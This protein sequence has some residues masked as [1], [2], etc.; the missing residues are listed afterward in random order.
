M[1]V[2]SNEAILDATASCLMQGVIDWPKLLPAICA[3]GT[4]V[5]RVPIGDSGVSSSYVQP[6]Y[7]LRMAADA[8]M[9]TGSTSGTHLAK[10]LVYTLQRYD[11]AI[12]NVDIRT[13][14]AV[15]DGEAGK[16][17]AEQGSAER[18]RAS[19]SIQ[20]FCLLL[21]HYFHAN[22]AG[23]CAYA[24]SLTIM[25]TLRPKNQTCELTHPPVCRAL[26]TY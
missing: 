18:Q 4:W 14:P 25:S 13:S 6:H 23:R 24:C 15:G 5:F 16:V 12:D 19:E 8:C 2:H 21:E 1:C 10:I 3:R 20:R 22:T 7:P 26:S 17:E 9:A 11:A